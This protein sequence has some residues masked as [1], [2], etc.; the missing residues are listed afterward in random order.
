MAAEITPS[1]HPTVPSPRW[2]VF[3]LFLISAVILFLELACIRWFPANVL[4]LTFF[5][6][7]VL[8]ACF[9]GMS[10]GCLAASHRRNYLTA[11][12]MILALAMVAANWV[13]VRH[14]QLEEVVDVGNQ[15]APQVVFFGTEYHAHND[16]AHFVIPVEVL[17]GFF[18]AAIALVMVGPGQELGRALTRLPNRIQ[19]YTVNIFGSIEGIVLFSLSSYLELS[20]GWW[21]L[22]IVLCIGY[23]LFQRSMWLLQVINWLLLLAI[24]LLASATSLRTLY[25]ENIEEY[26]SPYYRIEYH[27]KDLGISVN[28]IGHQQMHPLKSTAP[29]YAMPYLLNRDTGGRPFKDVLII[30][31]GSGNDVSRALQWGAEH[32]DAVEIDPHPVPGQ[33]RPSRQTLRPDRPRHGPPRRRAQFL[34][35]HRPEVRPGDLCTGGLAGAAKQL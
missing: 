16:V 20:P 4:F 29:A 22:P 15:N 13:E 23:F 18:F 25:K 31:E 19:A 1:A 26:W 2:P 21:F 27:P 28:M 35:F 24:V 6:N 33:A 9:L 17:G 14:S 10:L 8:L 3:D 7:T 30:G 32:I 5:T 11:T 34:A 12:P